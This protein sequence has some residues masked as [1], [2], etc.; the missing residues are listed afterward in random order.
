MYKLVYIV[1][2]DYPLQDLGNGVMCGNGDEHFHID[3]VWTSERKAKK[4]RNKLNSEDYKEFREDYGYG[5]FYI[6]QQ[7][8]CR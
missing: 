5:L 4:R 3:S 1:I 8:L 7:V 2:C 6:E